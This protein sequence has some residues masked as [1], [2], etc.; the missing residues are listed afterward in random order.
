MYFNEPAWPAKGLGLACLACAR[1]ENHGLCLSQAGRHRQ[2]GRPNG[3]FYPL[4]AID[5]PNT[6]GLWVIGGGEFESDVSFN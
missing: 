2:A 6:V 1:L 3:L 4:L 5:G